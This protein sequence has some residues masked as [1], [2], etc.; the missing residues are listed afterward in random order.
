MFMKLT[1]RILASA[2][3]LLRCVGASAANDPV[4][5]EFVYKKTPQGELKLVVTYPPAATTGDRRPAIVF[6][7]GG[8]WANSNLNQFKDFAPYLARRNMVAVR[9]D[10]RVSKTHDVT[11]DKCVEDAR[12]AMRWVRE[13]A[14]E[15]GVEPNRVAA[16]GA[17][18]GG[19][20]AAC[21]ATPVAPDSETDDLKVSC[22]PNALVL[23]NCVADLTPE[24]LATRVG[25]AEMARR[26]SP[27][28]HVS[29]K[30]PPTLILDGSEDNWVGTAKQFTD[31]AAAHGV[32]CEFYLA[33]GEGHQFL[34][35]SPWR[36]ASICKIDEFL[37]SLGWLTGPPVMEMPKVIDWVRYQPDPSAKPGGVIVPPTIRRAKA[38][39]KSEAADTADPK[40]SR[41]DAKRAEFM[42]RRMQQKGSATPP[43]PDAKPQNYDAESDV[44]PVPPAAAAEAKKGGNEDRRAEFLKRRREQKSK[45]DTPPL[46]V[47][48]KPSIDQ[49][50]RRAAAVS[51]DIQ[52]TTDHPVPVNP[53]VYGTWCEEMF[54]KG[55]A[56]NPEY[57]DAL[58]ELKF[59]TF[60]FPGGSLSYYHHPRGAGGFNIRPEE[61][62][63]SKY[64][65]EGSAAKEKAGA[66]RSKMQE[67]M[68]KGDADLGEM[69]IA[70][71]LKG[72]SDPDYFEQYIRFVKA[73]GGDAVFVANILNG[74]VD[75]L[76]EYLTRLRAERIPIAAVVL[77]VEMHLGPA[78]VLGLD[79]YVER[80]KPFIAMLRAKYADV[81][82]VAH[83][84]PVGRAPELARGEFHEWNQ[85]LT[86]LQGISGYSQYGWTEFLG[87]GRLQSRGAAAAQSPA[88]IWRQY[89][90]F[91]QTFSSRQLTAYQQDWGADKKMYLTQWGAHSDRN[92]ALLGL[93]I[94]N[95]YFFLAQHNAAHQD[96]FA[97]AT[98]SVSL[99]Q[100]SAKRA[101]EGGVLY[102]EKIELLTPYLYTKPFRHLFSGQ[103]KLLEATVQRGASGAEPAQAKTLAAVA[104]DG[105][106]F[107][108]VLN[109]GPAVALGRVS[110]DGASLPANQP[111]EVEAVWDARGADDAVVPPVK[112]FAGQ[113]KLADVILE[114]F[115]LTLLIVPAGAD[116]NAAAANSDPSANQTA[117][118][119]KAAASKKYDENAGP[120]PTH[121]DVSYGEHERLKLD[122]WQTQSAQ[123]T[124]VL[125]FYHGGGGDKLMYRGHPLQTFCLNHGISVA[126][127]NFRPNNQFPAPIPTQDAARA[128]Q[129]LRLKAG[130]FNIDPAR[131][132]SFGTSLG[133]NVSIALA[134]G[135]DL[136]DAKNEDPVRRESS[137]LSF[138][139]TADAGGGFAGPAASQLAKDAPPILMI[140]TMPL[141]EHLSLRETPRRELIHN[142]IFG[143]LLKHKLDAAG[144]ENYLYHGEN[145]APP[146][147]AE[148]FILKHFLLRK[149]E[150]TP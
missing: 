124:P 11:P 49:A 6:F 102:R 123:P 96:Y 57:V 21:T 40:T 35:R 14:T 54:A 140:Y 85:T 142:P 25:G 118:P 115:S 90:E 105:R 116:K 141:N 144:I 120:R 22:A 63:R 101:A 138:L 41:S 43:K 15:L 131:V 46:K 113:K 148:K 65:A 147:E 130:E 103:T 45:A 109:S 74:T 62:A 137:R 87:Q 30:T 126:A 52:I 24:P 88:D 75:E 34:G 111:V 69:I 38:P 91:V 127:V 136:A 64:G 108:Y 16:L 58:I 19:H 76:D 104:A 3:I 13:H 106:R 133:A 110:I 107:L 119:K 28:L 97:L 100:T 20:L 134:Y 79:G 86:K 70:R 80:I 114:P 17:S 59:K 55:L 27:V 89:D 67:K 92:T 33:E 73:S 48:P 53:R 129:F 132:A 2:L 135:D 143:H 95:Y 10:Y 26:V 36:E 23:F 112:T 60:L 32:R 50:E 37:T 8:A 42:K 72:N 77:G 4:E 66:T 39:A 7:S 117:R 61:L 98:S 99:A 71:Y 9:V 94:A 1:F 128:I 149:S 47:A 29:T 125:V 5:Q 121:E 68:G 93:H 146:D 78:K 18:A 150:P 56:N 31:Q 12:S 145:K 81:P 83:S 84:T 139:I 51:I 122:F 82:I 44:S